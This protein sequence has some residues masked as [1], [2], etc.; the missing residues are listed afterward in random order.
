MNELTTFIT[1]GDNRR[2]GVIIAIM[3]ISLVI[4]IISILL[5][6]NRKNKHNK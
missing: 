5:A 6:N 4:L 3:I 1:T 2:V